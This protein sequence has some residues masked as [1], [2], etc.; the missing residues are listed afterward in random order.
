MALAIGIILY[1]IY[2]AVCIAAAA[3]SLTLLYMPYVLG[4]IA[5]L[6]IYSQ[7]L[8]IQ[9]WIPGHPKMCL[10]VILAI[11][12]LGIAVLMHMRHVSKAAITFFCCAFMGAIG[13]VVF[14]GLTPDSVGYCLFVSVV[15][16]FLSAFAVQLNFRNLPEEQG[17]RGVLA[18]IISGVLYGLSAISIFGFLAE[19]IWKPFFVGLHHSPE[20]IEVV[21]N[22]MCVIGAVFIL[23]A[24]LFTDRKARM[25][26]RL[27]D[28]QN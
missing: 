7:N 27:S 23:L 15:Y 8:G 24:V 14:E 21:I 3:M 6:I 12:E 17:S 16:L 18:G 22:G 4:G 19:G 9:T 2:M 5:S 13:A 26:Q 1:L 11:V 28:M 20:R 10:I 25:L